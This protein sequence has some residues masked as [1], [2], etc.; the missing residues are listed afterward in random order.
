MAFPSQ[1]AIAFASDAMTEMLPI[2][3]P[4]AIT[5]MAVSYATKII[6][7]AAKSENPAVVLVNLA[8][9]SVRGTLNGAASLEVDAVALSQ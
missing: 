2:D 7:I 9:K 6:A 1:R 4:G 5:A 8:D 3:A